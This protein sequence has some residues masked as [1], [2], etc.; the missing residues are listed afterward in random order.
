MFFVFSQKTL[1]HLDFGAVNSYL[2]GTAL[3]NIMSDL[4]KRDE[5]KYEKAKTEQKIQ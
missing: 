4:N 5:R 2:N 1:W 3:T